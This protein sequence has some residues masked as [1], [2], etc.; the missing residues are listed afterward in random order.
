MFV[1]TTCILFYT[2]GSQNGQNRPPRGNF[3]W[4]RDD[5]GAKQHKG[6]ENA[7]PLALIVKPL[8]D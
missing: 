7:Q 2:S 5:K 3:E 4:Q 6:D 8:A 1:D